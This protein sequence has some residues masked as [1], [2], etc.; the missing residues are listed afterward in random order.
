[1]PR[2]DNAVIEASLLEDLKKPGAKVRE[3]GDVKACL[4][5]A[6][7]KIEATYYVPYIAHATM[8]PMNCTAHVQKDRCDIWAPTQG[9]TVAQLVGSKVSGISP[10][11]VHIHTTYLGCGLGR[12]AAPDFVVQAVIASKALG[13]PVKLVW[14]R[15]QD[16]KYDF[17]PGR[18]NPPIGREALM[19]KGH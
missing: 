7:K 19:R 15:E 2:L 16:F 13:K 18:H 17:F 3:V 1:M 9:Q 8:E 11:N 12:R 5:S 4:A 14:T 10:E 6:K